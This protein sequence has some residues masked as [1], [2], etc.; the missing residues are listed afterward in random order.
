MGHSTHISLRFRTSTAERSTLNALMVHYVET[1][2][3]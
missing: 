3:G 2:T 1:T